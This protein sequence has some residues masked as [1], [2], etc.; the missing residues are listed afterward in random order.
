[1]LQDIRQ[2]FHQER[3]NFFMLAGLWHDFFHQTALLRQEWQPD[4]I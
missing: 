1:L 3:W 2:K 4:G